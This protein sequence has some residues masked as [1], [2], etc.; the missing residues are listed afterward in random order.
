MAVAVV[1]FPGAS[2]SS[3]RRRQLAQTTAPRARRHRRLLPSH[4]A[5]RF[6]QRQWRGAAGRA[7]GAAEGLLPPSAASEGTP[8]AAGRKFFP[9]CSSAKPRAGG[10]GVKP[11]GVPGHAA[12]R[13]PAA[14]RRAA[15]GLPGEMAAGALPEM[16]AAAAAH[17]Q[18][19]SAAPG[20]PGGCVDAGWGAGG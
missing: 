11:P 15:A 20:C 3:G 12:P 9:L 8:P 19:L 5:G 2:S 1:A 4:P 16:A 17:P 7:P 6:P 10:S 14:R 18:P 13:R